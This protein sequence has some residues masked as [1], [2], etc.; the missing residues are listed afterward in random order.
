MGLEYF[1]AVKMTGITDGDFRDPAHLYRRKKEYT[2]TLVGTVLQIMEK[3]A[4]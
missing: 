3:E 4:A 2:E 1:D